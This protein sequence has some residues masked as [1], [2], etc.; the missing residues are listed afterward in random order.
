MGTTL[1]DDMKRPN[2]IEN[3]NASI[4]D[5]SKSRRIGLGK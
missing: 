1:R 5:I 3:A 2:C 4:I